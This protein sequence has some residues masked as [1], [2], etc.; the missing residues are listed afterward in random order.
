M[1]GI[2]SPLAVSPEEYDMPAQTPLQLGLECLKAG[3]IDEAIEYLERAT[4]RF[5][6][7]YQ[8]FNYLGVA[9]ARKEMYNRAVG[10][11]QAALRIRPNVPSIHYNLGLAYQADGLPEMA[12]EAFQNALR[13]EPSY[14]KAAEALRVL[15][16]QAYEEMF[17]VQ[18]CARH[19]D[20]PSEGVCVLCRLPVCKR[21]KR[22][23]NDQIFCSACAA[24]QARS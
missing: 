13:L 23:I 15:D 17:S 10:A 20:T 2:R 19:A 6:E 21:C 8:G 7:D 12:R 4:A 22:V 5:P 16:E 18:A 1:D 3:K 11:F 14:D 9:Y 24:K